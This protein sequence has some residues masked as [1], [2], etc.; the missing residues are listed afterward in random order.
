MSQSRQSAINWRSLE[1]VSSDAMTLRALPWAAQGAVRARRPDSEPPLPVHDLRSL[2]PT[3]GVFSAVL[4]TDLYFL[5][6]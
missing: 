3:R 6:S 2:P 5:I 1:S 4:I